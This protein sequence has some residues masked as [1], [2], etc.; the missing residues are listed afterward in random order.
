M[1]LA[2]EVAPQPWRACGGGEGLGTALQQLGDALVFRL[3][4][5]R[6][7]RLPA[8]LRLSPGGQEH[9]GVRLVVLSR[10]VLDRAPF[11]PCDVVHARS[12]VH[13][14]FFQ[15]HRHHDEGRGRRLGREGVNLRQRPHQR[16]HHR[17]FRRVRVGRQRRGEADLHQRPRGS[18][19]YQ[20]RRGVARA[21]SRWLSRAP[22]ASLRLRGRPWGLIPRHRRGGVENHGEPFVD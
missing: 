9:P 20:C 4:R 2:G 1:P 10:G 22:L 6:G 17:F 14:R 12:Q 21:G 11:G 18:E 13:L 19:T 3:R 16:G 5:R 15:A 8:R 7:L